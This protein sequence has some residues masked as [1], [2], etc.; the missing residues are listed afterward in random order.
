MCVAGCALSERVLQGAH[1]TM[2]SE[3]ALL[4]VHCTVIS[5]R[6]L[7]GMYCVMPL[8]FPAFGLL[9]HLVAHRTCHRGLCGGIASNR[10]T[11]GSL[12]AA[13]YL[14]YQLYQSTYNH[15]YLNV[16][17]THHTHL[18]SQP[19]RQRHTPVYVFGNITTLVCV[20][21]GAQGCHVTELGADQ[22]GHRVFPC[23][24]F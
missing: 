5:E 18:H 1:R 19:D 24:R 22:R 15:N 6:A 21:L 3:R 11:H 16:H 4:G 9:S 2:A 7:Q 14:E 20:W 23:H 10:Y 8:S 17:L 12:C 13:L